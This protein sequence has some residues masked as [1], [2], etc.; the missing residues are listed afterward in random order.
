MAKFLK[1][2][3]REHQEFP[4]QTPDLTKQLNTAALKTSAGFFFFLLIFSEMTLPR[5]WHGSIN[6]VA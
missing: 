5:T 6:G 4:A 1:N 3:E 2:L